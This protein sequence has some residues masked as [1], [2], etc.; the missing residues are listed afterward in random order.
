MNKIVRNVEKKKLNYK[1]L[2]I[3][4]SILIVFV[5]FYVFVWQYIRISNN[6]YSFNLEHNEF[7]VSRNLEHYIERIGNKY[8]FI[9]NGNTVIMRISESEQNVVIFE[10]VYNSEH[11]IYFCSVDEN[12]I[13]NDIYNIYLYKG[14][15]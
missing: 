1:V 12:I 15:K 6:N 3:I 11:K 10:N 13:F 8:V 14:A 9:N 2:L 7:Y 4:L 5:L